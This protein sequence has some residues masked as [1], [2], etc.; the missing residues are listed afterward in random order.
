LADEGGIE[1]VELRVERP[2]M[3]RKRYVCCSKAI[4]GVCSYNETVTVPV[5]KSV[6]RKRL[7]AVVTD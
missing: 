4:F 7:V 2:A 6:T 5:L 1:R 3:K